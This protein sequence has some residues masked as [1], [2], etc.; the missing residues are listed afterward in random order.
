MT[1]TGWNSAVLVLWECG[2][3]AVCI[4]VRNVQRK[5]KVRRAP[6]DIGLIMVGERQSMRE[7]ERESSLD[8]AALLRLVMPGCTG[9][10]HL[11]WQP[12]G[13]SG[14]INQDTLKP[15]NLLQFHHIFNCRKCTV[16][17]PDCAFAFSSLTHQLNS[18]ALVL[19]HHTYISLHRHKE[20]SDSSFC[21]LKNDKL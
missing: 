4:K 11:P 16:C 14:K 15:K 1:T 3:G 10:P 12:A 21:P 8:L 20:A 13:N 7:R 9:V 5:V 19:W 6:K 17:P 2:W 18:Y